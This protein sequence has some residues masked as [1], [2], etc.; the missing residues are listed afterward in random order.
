MDNNFTDEEKKNQQEA[1]NKLM[2]MITADRIK[3]GTATSKDTYLQLAKVYKSI[4]DA[5][6]AVGFTK[7][8]AFEL[9]KLEVSSFKTFV[10][11]RF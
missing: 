11:R 8:E 7:E 10:N 3:N 4:Y 6:I 1:V 5:Y 9:L 2:Q